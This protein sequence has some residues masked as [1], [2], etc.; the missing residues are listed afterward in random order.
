L[1]ASATKTPTE[2]GLAGWTVFLDANN[3]GIL[4]TG[5]VDTT[6]SS[7]SAEAINNTFTVE[8]K[9]YVGATTTI[10]DIDV[11]LDITHTFDG[12][13][14]AYLVSP[15]GTRVKLFSNI[16][17]SGDNFQGTSFDDGALQSIT[18][19]TAPFSG[20]FKPAELLAAF[21]GENSL[22]FWTLEIKDST[23]ADNGSLNTWSLTI[24][25]DER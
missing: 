3:N 18:A 22:G 21:N 8:S 7:T 16:G 12:D 1:D 14:S 25:G 5:T 13:L 10:S 17:S 15:S 19:G 6:V 23:P 4:D 11:T 24:K 20:A 2:P 9:L